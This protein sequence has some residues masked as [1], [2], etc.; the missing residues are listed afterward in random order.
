MEGSLQASVMDLKWES[1]VLIVDKGYCT[2]ILEPLA[3]AIRLIDILN[4]TVP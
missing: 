2:G 4:P 3:A 1:L